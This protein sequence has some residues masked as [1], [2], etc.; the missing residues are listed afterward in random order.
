MYHLVVYHN[1]LKKVQENLLYQYLWK[2]VD[3]LL[4]EQAV[5]NHQNQM[6][7]HHLVELEEIVVWGIIHNYDIKL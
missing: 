6:L 3:T 4:L 1:P 2:E 5:L 7:V